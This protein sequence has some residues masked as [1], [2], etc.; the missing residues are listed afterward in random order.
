MM[1]ELLKAFSFRLCFPQR[2]K[3]AKFSCPCARCLCGINVFNLRNY[4]RCSTESVWNKVA[5]RTQRT[6]E[7][8]TLC[9][10]CFTLCS[11]CSILK[12]QADFLPPSPIHIS[13]KISIIFDEI[14]I[15]LCLQDY[16][17]TRLLL[18]PVRARV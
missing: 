2:H 16:L 9:P 1:D 7:I 15:H 3:P 10:L 4:P 18:L 11:L 8:T 13:L 12:F 6:T 5:Q 14:L 17:S